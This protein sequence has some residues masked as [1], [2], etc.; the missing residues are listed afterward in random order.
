[1]KHKSVLQKGAHIES[2]AKLEMFY[3]LLYRDCFWDNSL[4]VAA[5]GLSAAAGDFPAVFRGYTD[6]GV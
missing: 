5:G 4:S 3:C 2:A 1:M 6:A